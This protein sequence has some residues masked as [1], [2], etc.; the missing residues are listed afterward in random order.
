MKI[1]TIILSAAAVALINSCSLF[2]DKSN[3]DN[4][5]RIC[6]DEIKYGSLAYGDKIYKTVT[7]CKQTWMAENLNYD[8][9]G[10]RCYNDDPA[11]CDKYGRLYNWATA[12]SICPEGWYLP[13]NKEWNALIEATGG[14]NYAAS[15]LKNQSDWNDNGNG[16]ND[17]GFSALPGGYYYNWWSPVWGDTNSFEE[18]GTR[19]FWWSASMEDA[20]RG[21][22]HSICN[23]EGDYGQVE[24]AGRNMLSLRS[25]RCIQGEPTFVQ[26]NKIISGT[27]TDSRDGKTYKWVEIGKQTWMA[28][29][30]NYN[31]EG[32]K[33]YGEGGMAWIDGNK[34]TLSEEEAQANCE[35]Y[36]RLYDWDMSMSACPSGWHLPRDS[37]WDIL[38]E[39]TGGERVIDPSGGIRLERVSYY[40]TSMH[41]RNKNGWPF[42]ALVTDISYSDYDGY[43]N[44]GR[45]CLDSYG[46][47]AL[48]G[49][50][51]SDLS[52]A[53]GSIIIR[54]DG[55]YAHTGNI[56][57]GDL[58]Y[59]YWWT[60]SEIDVTFA[61]LVVNDY[62][63][64]DKIQ[65]NY[66]TKIGYL[67]IR[68]VKD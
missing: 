18:V 51:G 64:G 14:A 58:T 36:G 25:V 67:G 34:I 49:G 59:P 40:N 24:A 43:R 54:P 65:I 13:S 42:C 60:G 11:N 29:N 21:S 48:P 44:S 28:E 16:T 7:I 4:D 61:R 26:P 38:L 63:F 10:S 57:Y 8:I 52:G 9:E 17:Y 33:C 27:F 3:D 62:V 35:K 12:T 5:N 20:Y 39:A 68:C 19:G 56:M 32:S 1:A 22:T 31:A 41:L 66:S 6:K 53:D 47:S 55:S 37:E 50:D 30:L 15:H 2:E 45:L 23:F 46:F